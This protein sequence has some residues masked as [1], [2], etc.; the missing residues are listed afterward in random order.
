MKITLQLKLLPDAEQAGAF[1]RTLTQFNAA[2]NSVAEAAF[3]ERLANKFELQKLV[4]RDIR[5]RFDI[6]ADMA[7]RVIAQVVEA[8]KRD[9]SKQPVFKP[10][11]SVPYS[12]GRNYSF[13]GMD[14]VSIQVAPSGRLIVPFV[15]GQYQRDRF[16]LAKGQADLVFRD[17]QWFLYV[18][19]DVPDVAAKETADFIGVDLGVENI[20]TDSD[21]NTTNSK[22][23]EKV[24]RNLAGRRRRLGRASGGA[25]RKKRRHCHKAIVRLKRRESRFRKDINHVIS[26][27]LVDTAKRTGRGIALEDLKGIRERVRL[28][29]CQRARHDS[30][31][32]AQLRAFIEY[33]AAMAGVPVVAVDARY[34]SQTCSACGHCERSNRK[35]QSE[36]KCRSCG[37]V[38]HADRNAALNIRAKAVVNRPRG[39]EQPA[40][41]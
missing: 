4:Y 17:E 31:A 18:S 16:G 41:A 29:K 3:K 13:K 37:F 26:K 30:W 20:A 7:I 15:C 39:S 27:S 1:A 2:A 6:P 22:K 8:Y 28:R 24:R 12:Y 33:K 32:Y 35:S 21:G 36:F 40:M 38:L 5:N 25:S 9:R 19:I 11:A 14:R 34:T 10:L 23:I